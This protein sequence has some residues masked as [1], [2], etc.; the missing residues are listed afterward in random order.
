MK[1]LA[2]LII[3]RA[4]LTSGRSTRFV[5]FGE[6]VYCPYPLRARCRRRGASSSLPGPCFISGAAG[7]WALGRAPFV[8]PVFMGSAERSA[9]GDPLPPMA[10]TCFMYLLKNPLFLLVPTSKWRGGP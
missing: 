1:P 2:D 9:L 10:P 7:S 8:P 3:A 5:I 4:R 6:V